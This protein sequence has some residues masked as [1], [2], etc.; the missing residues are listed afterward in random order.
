MIYMTA[1][2]W[3]VSICNYVCMFI[4]TFFHTFDIPFFHIYVHSYVHT[5]ILSAATPGPPPVYSEII[6]HK[7]V[8]KTSYQKPESCSPYL[9]PTPKPL[10]GEEEEKRYIDDLAAM[11]PTTFGSPIKRTISNTSS[12]IQALQEKAVNDNDDDSLYNSIHDEEEQRGGDGGTNEGQGGGGQYSEIAELDYQYFKELNK[13]DDC[14]GGVQ[15]ISIQGNTSVPP[16]S[17][18]IAPISKEPPPDM[19]TIHYMAA[20]GDKKALEGIL[21]LLPIIQDPVESVLGS[22]KFQIREGVNVRDGYGRTPLMHAVYNGH[23]DCVKVL[24]EAGANVNVEASG[25]FI[26]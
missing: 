10:F 6:K 20:I 15:L 17:S 16:P 25:K 12:I 24:C 4:H 11:S 14:E 13:H 1:S 2:Q 7:A 8:S 21:A 23:M 5:F 18:I 19:Q 26:N 3:E 9:S 22:S